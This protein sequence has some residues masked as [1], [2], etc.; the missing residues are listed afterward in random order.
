ML[1]KLLF[2]HLPNHYPA[3]SAYAHF[4]FLVP[5]F[6]KEH[7]KKLSDNPVDKYM[8]TRPPV[9][10]KLVVATSYD[11]VSRILAEREIFI[12]DY[13]SRMFKLTKGV[14]LHPQLVSLTRNFVVRKFRVFWKINDVLLDDAQIQRWRSSFFR[15]TGNLIKDKSVNHVG[16][17]AKYVDIVKDVI[18]L[19][20]VHWIADE[21][22][23]LLI[24]LLC[25]FLT[26]GHQAGLPMK[27]DANPR[28]VFR[29]QEL[30]KLFANVA[31]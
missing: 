30:Y 4:P 16:S 10:T 22:A 8:W 11:A 26:S 27:S 18:N 19:L 3:G 6:I 1:T 9:P 31:K 20:P 23:S 17:S 12:S 5:S 14:I 21:I 24:Q 15:I 28:G 13:H 25:C 7:L 29:E 2:R